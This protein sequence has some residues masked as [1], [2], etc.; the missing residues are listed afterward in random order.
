[1]ANSLVN[2][3]IN[4]SDNEKLDELTFYLEKKRQKAE[5]SN[6]FKVLFILL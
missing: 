3:V 6:V 1:V 2:Y 4:N 5:V